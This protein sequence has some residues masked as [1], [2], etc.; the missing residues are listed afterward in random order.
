LEAAKGTSRG[1]VKEDR[2]EAD[3]EEDKREDRE[4]DREEDGRQR[5]VITAV[6]RLTRAK[7]GPIKRPETTAGTGPATGIDG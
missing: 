5:G 7:A 6:E 1:K 4:E 3:R 2:E